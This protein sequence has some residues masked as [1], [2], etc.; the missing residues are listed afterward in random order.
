MQFVLAANHRMKQE[1]LRCIRSLNF[2]NAS[3]SVYDLG[4]LGIGTPWTVH[5][6]TFQ[7]LGYYRTHYPC[8]P[9]RSMHKAE[10]VMDFCKKQAEGEIVCYLDCD[11]EVLKPVDEIGQTE[12][13]VGV[14]VFESTQRKECHWLNAGVIF[15]RCVPKTFQFIEKWIYNTEYY[16]NDQRGLSRTVFDGD[17]RVHEFSAEIYNYNM[18]SPLQP[19]ESTK[20]LHYFAS[21]TDPTMLRWVEMKKR[22]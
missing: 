11:T 16:G 21:T 2:L 10:I 14:T 20:I 4:G 3:Y 13:D 1:T 18:K 12:F 19:N 8:H 22:K 7:V 17:W 5:D 6:N 15:F 9:S